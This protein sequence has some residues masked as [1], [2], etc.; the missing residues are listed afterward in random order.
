MPGRRDWQLQRP[1]G[2]TPD[3]REAIVGHGGDELDSETRIHTQ[4]GGRQST[5]TLTE[6][7]ARSAVAARAPSLRTG[8]ASLELDR[9]RG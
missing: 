6:L 3:S 9:A 2:S 1:G 8:S 5:Q 4:H 7:K